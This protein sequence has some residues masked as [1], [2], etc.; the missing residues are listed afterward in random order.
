[1]CVFIFYD[2]FKYVK[3]VSL[4]CKHLKAVTQHLKLILSDKTNKQK[5]VMNVFTFC[6]YSAKKEK[7]RIWKY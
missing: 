4:K 3:Y 7:W 6:N 5:K 1:M 2:I